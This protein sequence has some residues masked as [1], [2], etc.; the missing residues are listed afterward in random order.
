M[1]KVLCKQF[2]DQCVGKSHAIRMMSSDDFK[3]ANTK[4]LIQY[5]LHAFLLFFIDLQ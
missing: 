1:V 2:S 5:K 3:F 4:V